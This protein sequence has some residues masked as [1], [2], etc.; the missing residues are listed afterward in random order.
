MAHPLKRKI[1][2]LRS[3]LRRLVL[4][5][6]V[7]RIITAVLGMTLV[8]TAADFLVRF[9]ETG[10]RV[11]CTLVVFGLAAWTCFRCVRRALGAGLGDVE[12]A[13]RVER[14]FPRLRGRLAS[15]LEFLVQQEDDPTAGSAALRRA[16]VARSTDEAHDVDMGKILHRRPAIRVAIL[17]AVVCVAAAI[18]VVLDP[19]SSEIALARLVKPLGGDVWPQI[20][21]LEVRGYKDHL[22]MGDTFEIEVVDAPGVELPQEV[23]IYYRIAQDDDTT[24]ETTETMDFVDGA[25]V[26]RRENVARSFEFRV[27]GG[28]DD[29]M[30]KR[31]WP[32]EVIEP[33]RLVA[34]TLRVHLVPPDYT[35]RNPR[36]SAGDVT[37]LVGTRMTVGGRSSKRLRSAALCFEDG[38]EVPADLSEDGF[39]FAVPDTRAVV[40]HESSVYWLR[41]ADAEK[42]IVG[43]SQRWTIRAEADDP[44]K[45][46]LQQPAQNIYVTPGAVV[47]VRISAAD[48]LALRR[49]AMVF[50][51]PGLDSAAR[52]EVVLHFRPEPPR[53]EPSSAAI[54]SPEEPPTGESR[55]VWHPWELAPLQLKPPAQL[56]LHAT[57]D[58]FRSTEIDPGAGR[59]T[60]ESR[61]LNVISVRE[62][63]DRLAGRQSFVLAELARMLALQRTAKKQTAGLAAAWSAI[64]SL[65]PPQ[66]DRLQGAELKQR[67]VNLVLSSRTEGLPVHLE[68]ILADLQ[69]NRLD[70]P[71]LQRRVQTI[72]AELDRLAVERLPL[73]ARGLTAA[74]KDAQA[75]L[76]QHGDDARSD[77]AHLGRAKLL[78][79]TA[80]HQQ[81]VIDTLVTLLGELA[82][83]DHCRRFHR[84][85]SQ[86]MSEEEET[87]G[88]TAR[89]MTP[90]TLA[91]DFRDLRP[92]EQA[93]RLILA[94]E[95]L[96]LALQLERIQ[97]EMA[98]VCGASAESESPAVGIVADALD[99]ARQLATSAKMR[100][101]SSDIR[102]NRLGQVTARQKQITGELQEL[103]DILSNRREHELDRLVGMIRRA[104]TEL[105]GLI[106][107]QTQLREAADRAAVEADPAR[108]H[109]QLKQFSERQTQVE[110]HTRKLVRQLRRL[111]AESAVPPAS[112]A[113]DQMRDARESA[114]RDA[115]LDMRQGASAAEKLLIDAAGELARRRFQAEAEL[116]M[117][118]LA[119]LQAALETIRQEQQTV[120]NQTVELDENRPSI[121][122]AEKAR[123]L[124]PRQRALE[125]AV[126]QLA[127]K[128]LAAKV[129]HLAL[130][131]AADEMADAAVRLTGGE[132]GR[133][134]QSAQ[135]N[136][137]NR[138]A[139][140]LDAVAPEDP[141]DD[142]GEGP[143]RAGAGP[144]GP[145]GEAAEG[146]QT[147]AELKLIRLLQEDVYLRTQAIQKITGGRV[148]SSDTLK[149]RYVALS[150]DQRRLAQLVAML[151]GDDS[152][153]GKI[154]GTGTD[155]RDPD[156]EPRFPLEQPRLP[157]QEPVFPLEQ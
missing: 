135:Q 76:A 41:M 124:E 114:D 28:D 39:G 45:V 123:A 42:P 1:R 89:A 35:G 64:G 133:D 67:Q 32:V 138:I 156:Q 13:L 94:R 63:E 90:Q 20:H 140:I 69:N 80:G 38:S 151:S 8:V 57:A 21:Y 115:P 97:Q 74:I 14:R 155:P 29:S 131:G 87:A 85:I 132:V 43:R 144:A 23:R 157:M 148:P 120:L 91:K 73:I 78:S 16:V 102:D 86:L 22:A 60:S 106:G 75:R 47:P 79:E 136:A 77:E 101:G 108:R 51:P 33:P 11:L 12:L 110:A 112:Q 96:E 141:G 104:E 95:Q 103:L 27:E 68:S 152:P 17:S 127:D 15:A 149:T 154:P 122:L 2:S 150:A 31:W 153:Q 66:I 30:S 88:R 58:D 92:E 98:A 44:P 84:E 49:I 111:Q 146:V 99:R 56:V 46:T 130:T 37:A 82:R 100:Q 142:G 36:E 71:G 139:M 55:L 62:F 129:I 65:D 107:A 125:S 93:Q 145:E 26:A 143:D 118:Q 50:G 7:G 40:L 25:M 18:L 4:L 61:L 105:A 24:A 134:T 10:L 6:G 81:H 70:N 34:E 147:L 83:W 117:E 52:S 121:D 113:A 48:R 128:L 59:G 3:R 19:A 137:L 126:R 54:V 72:L 116:A 53:P 109:D 5:D 119:R 9:E